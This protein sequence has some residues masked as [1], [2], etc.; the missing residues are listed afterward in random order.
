MEN[1]WMND[2]A[3]SAVPRE[4]LDFLQQMVFESKKLSQ[5]EMLPF[6]MAL[7]SKA[8]SANISFSQEEMTAIISVLENHSSPADLAKMHQVMKMMKFR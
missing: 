1:E 5:K 8:K 3:L 7:A 2:P 4:K 6:F